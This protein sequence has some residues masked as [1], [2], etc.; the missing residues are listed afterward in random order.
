MEI[1]AISFDLDGTLIETNDAWH[2]ALDKTLKQLGKQGVTRQYFYK[3]HI[4]VD[5]KKVISSHIPLTEPELEKARLQLIDNFLSSIDYVQIIDNVVYVLDFVSSQTEKSAIITNTYRKVV[6]RVVENLKSRNLD[7]TKYFPCIVTR[8]VVSEGKPKPDII[9]YACKELGVKPSNMVFVEDS[10]SGVI[11]G[12]AAGCYVVALTSTTSEERL[13]NAGADMVI[14]NLL[15]L[16]QIITEM[17]MKSAHA[18]TQS[19]YNR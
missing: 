10:V 8:D 4:G 1:D 14:S 9:Y 3:N 19:G 17:N 6:D 15:E 11:A 7:L 2:Q 5:M 16:K 12:K 13:R 18:R